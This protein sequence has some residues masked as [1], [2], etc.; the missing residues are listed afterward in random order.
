MATEVMSTA[1]QGWRYEVTRPSLPEV[2]STLAV[3]HK[4]N[5]FRKLFAFAGSGFLVAVGYMTLATGRP[6]WLPAR[7]STIRSFPS[8]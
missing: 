6:I 1:E 7:D 2:H 3:P 8:S 5:F 4:A